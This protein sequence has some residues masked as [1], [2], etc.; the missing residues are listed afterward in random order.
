M[1]G[2]GLSKILA[3][4]NM[5]R[6]EGSCHNYLNLNNYTPGAVFDGFLKVKCGQY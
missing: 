3:P 4:P 6:F 5:Y 2:L 1:V